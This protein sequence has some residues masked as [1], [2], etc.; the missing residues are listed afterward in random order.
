MEGCLSE[1]GEDG[2]EGRLNQALGT[3]SSG[4]TITRE[5]KREGRWLHLD[6]GNVG[7]VRRGGWMEVTMISLGVEISIARGVAETEDANYCD[8]FL[9]FF[10]FFSFLFKSYAFV[11]GTKTAFSFNTTANK[12]GTLL[13][14]GNIQ[15]PKSLW[16]E[17]NRTSRLS[18]N[19][20]LRTYTYTRTK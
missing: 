16:Y 13:T 19:Q 11:E 9:S 7:C 12:S 17:T 10:F 20:I 5:R 15:T 6:R 8:S 18:P 3:S 4:L 14:T 2:G 1:P